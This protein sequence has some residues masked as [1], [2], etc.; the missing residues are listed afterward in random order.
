MDSLADSV[1]TSNIRILK[2][3]ASRTAKQAVVVAIGAVLLATLAVASMSSAGLSLD[4]IGRAQASNPVLWLLDA[5]PFVF[6]YLGQYSSYVIAHQAGQLVMEQTDELRMRANQL[7]Q[8][9]AFAVTHDPI[10]E[11]PNRALFNDRLERALETAESK[12]AKLAVLLLALGNFKEIQD[13]LGPASADLILKQLATRLRS[14]STNLDSIAHVESHTFAILLG[15]AALDKTEVERTAHLLQRLLDAPFVVNQLKLTLH[16]NIGIVFA[17]E[18]GDDPDTLLQRAGVA[19]YE[20]TKTHNGYAVY[21]PALDEH[22]PRRLTLMGELRRAI[23]HGELELHYQPKV[24]LASNRVIGAEALVRWPHP[25]HGYIPPEEFIGLAERTRLIRP[26]TH[27]VMD[28]AFRDCAAWHADGLNLAISINLSAKDLHDPEL[29]DQIAGVMARTNIEAGWIVFEITESSIMTD[30]ARVLNVLER[31]NGMGFQ[32]SIDDFGTGYSSLA[33]LKRLPV[34]EIKID[35]SFVMDMLDSSNDAVIVR[36]TIDLAHNLG[37][38]VTAEGVENAAAMDAL[39]AY[40]CDVTQGYLIS[41]P[42]SAESF[43]AWMASSAW[44]A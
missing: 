9:A 5:L 3:S 16:A 15:E 38:K 29:P 39:R 11:L 10:T 23:E 7:E 24:D 32:V 34:S 44:A 26:L 6:G 28:R 37:K 12:T 30:P 1:L 31:I 14:W 43:R 2:A 35:K 13:A 41:R 19:L 33:Y 21:S 27:W 18:H 17:P 22:S 8:Q 4:S 36:A 20:A 40:G 25:E 42:M